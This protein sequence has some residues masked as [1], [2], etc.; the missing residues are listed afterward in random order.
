MAGETMITICGNAVEDATLRFTQSGA[1]V[2]GFRIASTPRTFNKQTNTWEDGTTLYLTCNCW[3]DLA[4][5]VAESVTRGTALIVQGALKQREYEK[6]GQKRTVYEIEATDVAVSLRRATAVV[7]KA[8]KSGGQQQSGGGFGGQQRPQQGQADPWA[9][10]AP[11]QQAAG[12]W[13]AAPQQQSGAGFSDE[14]PF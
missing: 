14:P 11:Q 10:S 7:T 5:N 12:G 2:A 13:G 9:S 1:A 4:E 3:R 6:D 8:Q